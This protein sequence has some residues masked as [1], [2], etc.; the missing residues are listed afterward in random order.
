ML[1]NWYLVVVEAKVYVFVTPG[2][3]G[4]KPWICWIRASEDRVGMSEKAGGLRR[5]K[6][7]NGWS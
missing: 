1:E 6:Y 3:M 4:K 2:R 5:E 7:P